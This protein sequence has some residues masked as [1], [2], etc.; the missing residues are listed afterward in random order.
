MFLYGVNLTLSYSSL[1]QCCKTNLICDFNVSKHVGSTKIIFIT[2][3]VILYVN[4]GT[5]LQER[6][7]I[8]DFMKKGVGG[9]E[10]KY[11]YE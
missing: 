10:N 11:K 5:L 1:N 2:G 8:L 7:Y 4:N 6:V 9:K 3:T